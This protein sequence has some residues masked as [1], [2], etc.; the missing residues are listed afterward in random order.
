LSNHCAGYCFSSLFFIFGST[1][2]ALGDNA[3]AYVL[4]EVSQDKSSQPAINKLGA[5][6]NCKGS[7]IRGH[8]N[9]IIATVECSSLDDLNIAIANDLKKIPGVN[10][11]TL[12]RVSP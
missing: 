10:A 11:V 1:Q 3:R 7:G 4:I 2:I 6:Q 5:L 8:G 12:M 9:E